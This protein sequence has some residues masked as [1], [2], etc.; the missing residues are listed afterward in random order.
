MSYAFSCLI[1]YGS[2]HC[3]HGRFMSLEFPPLQRGARKTERLQGDKI[4]SILHRSFSHHSSRHCQCLCS[5]AAS[6]GYS[7]SPHPTTKPFWRT[8]TPSHAITLLLAGLLRTRSLHSP[9][10]AFIFHQSI[11]NH[12]SSSDFI[13]A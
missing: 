8:P 9:D 4:T 13:P 7:R 11:E 2:F 12:H 1:P 6:V 5:P 10:F 3:P